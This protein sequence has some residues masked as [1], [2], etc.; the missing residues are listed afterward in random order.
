MVLVPEGK[1][2]MG[3]ENGDTNEKPIHQVYLDT[4]YID[5][6]EM[7]NAH[8]RSCVLADA[9][10]APLQPISITRPDY[11]DS[12]QFDN[13]PVIYVSWDMARQYCDWRS[14]RLPQEWRSVILIMAKALGNSDFYSQALG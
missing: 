4:F 12:D 5:K 6:Y 2:T 3:S 11:Y 13:Y 7:T 14:A 8:Y 1:F 9:C 10:K